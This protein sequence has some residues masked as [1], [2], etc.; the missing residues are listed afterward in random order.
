MYNI[1]VCDDDREIV[2]A[3]EIYLVSEG[4]NVLKAYNGEEALNII[5]KNE[6]HLLLIDIMMP[7]LDGIHATLDIRKN[8]NIPIIILSAKSEDNDKVLGLNVGAD[9]YITKPFSSV[10]LLARVKSQLRRYTKLGN[11]AKKDDDLLVNGGLVIDD[12]KKLVQVDGID[13]KVTPIEYEILLFLIKNKG[14]VFSTNQIYER[15]WNEEAIASDN[16]VAVHIRH[17]REK[18]EINPKEPRYIKVVWGQGYKM[19]DLKK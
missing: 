16:I 9:D 6:I 17:I 1:L 8:S 12:S 5:N 3:I 19:E 2:E 11:I 14:L 13:I 4:Y 15:I 10:E 7:K 18:I